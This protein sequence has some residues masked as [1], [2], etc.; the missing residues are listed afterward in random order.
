MV[1]SFCLFINLPVMHFINFAFR[2]WMMVVDYEEFE[3]AD[4]KIIRNS[5]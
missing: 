4:G 2:G 1:I 5:K 3:S